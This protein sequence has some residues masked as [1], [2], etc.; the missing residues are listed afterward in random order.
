MPGHVVGELCG[1]A[2]AGKV[3]AD[4]IG[5]LALML[6]STTLECLT[7]MTE[8]YPQ[9]LVDP[10]GKSPRNLTDS[11]RHVQTASAGF[12]HYWTNAEEKEAFDTSQEAF[13]HLDYI[14][15]EILR[16]RDVHRANGATWPSSLFNSALSTTV[17]RLYNNA[18]DHLTWFSKLPV[19][20]GAM[21]TGAI[22]L[23]LS[24]EK[25]LNK[26]KHRDSVEIRFSISPPATHTLY[27]F[28]RFGMGQPDSISEINISEFCTACKS[29][30]QHI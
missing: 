20:K 21:P 8:R 12:I 24:L 10:T 18:T 2:F 9:F 7:A 1:V 26:L 27:L 30:A 5:Q 11:I 29:A 4:R 23:P 22:L 14:Q 6:F 16:Q 3:K 28:T 19:D 17:G 13:E 25:A 15:N